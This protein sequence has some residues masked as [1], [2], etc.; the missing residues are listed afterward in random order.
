MHN[1]LFFFFDSEWVRIALP[2]VTATTVPTPA[3]QNYVLQQLPRGGVD[4]ITGSTYQPAPQLVPF[5]QKLFSLYGNTAGTPL[6]VLGCPFNSDGSAAAGN[7]PN[8][9]GCAN[10]QSV[11][12]SSDDREQV[13]TGRIDYNIDAN[14]MAWFRFQSDTGLQAAYTDPINPLFNAISPQPLYSFAAGYTHVFLRTPGELFQSG[15]LV[16]REPV[17]PAESC[18]RRWRHFRS[19]SRAAGRMLRSRR[20]AGST[21]RGCRDGALRASS[22]T[23]IWRGP[24]ARMNSASEPIRRI[25]RLNDYD[26]GEGTVPLVTYTNLP[27]FIY[28]VASTATETF[29]L[30]DSQPFNFLNLDFYAQDTWKVTRTLT[31]TFGI[32]DTYN[33]NPLNPHDELARLAGSFASISH[34][35][36]QPLS[37]VIQT[38]LGTCLRFDAGWRSCSREPPSRG[39]SRPHTVL[40]TRVRTVQRYPARQRRRSGGHESAVFENLSGRTAGDG[41]RNGDRAGSSEQR[42]R[43]DRRREPD[44]RFRLRARASF[45]AHRRWPIRMRACRR[46]RSPPFRTA[47]CTR[48]TSC[49]GASALEHQIGETLQSARAVCG[50]ARGQPAVY[51]AGERLSDGVRGLLR[52]VSL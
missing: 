42:R 43:C 35:V 30:A 28:G 50:D 48:P 10:R 19:C 22:S 2:I 39:R 41:R 52:A 18:R 49:N 15:V 21:T 34:D 51:D 33:S 17:R 9:N 23:T 1:K 7:P 13:Q 25:F 27:Q 37:R 36:N 31:W 29:P 47:N 38:Q 8:G 20:S 14:N 11:S 45:P 3:F 32:R 6:A 44:F 46:F 24:P 4:S 5:Y 12:H 40:R 26:F 16:V